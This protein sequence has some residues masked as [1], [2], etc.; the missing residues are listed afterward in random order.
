MLVA[1]GNRHV[2]FLQGPGSMFFYRFA[3][4]LLRSGIKVSKIH[5]S[6]GDMVFWGRGDSTMF[7]RRFDEWASFVER[8]MI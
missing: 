1:A 8:Y 3:L 7:R 6:F 4:T 2:L 5:L